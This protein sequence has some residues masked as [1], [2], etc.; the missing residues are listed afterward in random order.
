MIKLKSLLKES[1]EIT[2]DDIENVL[3]RRYLNWEEKTL[4]NTISSF[5]YSEKEEERKW[6]IEYINLLNATSKYVENLIKKLNVPYVEPIGIKQYLLSQT[7]FKTKMEEFFP[8]PL[9]VSSSPEDEATVG[10]LIDMEGKV[11]EIHEGN[12]EATPETINMVNRMV[13]PKGKPVRVYASHD[14]NL[15]HRIKETGFLPKDLFVSPNKGHAL[16]HMDLEGKRSTFTGIIDINSVN[17]TSDLDWRTLEAT[18]IER[19][20]WL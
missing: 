3:T 2:I 1:V 15:V 8:F 7:E 6:A 19:F 14:T 5:Y 16:S 9:Y 18:K 4:L 17:Q 13:N 10:I 20:R 11:L 12:D